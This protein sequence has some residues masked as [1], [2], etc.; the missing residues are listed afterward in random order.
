LL[1]W[2]SLAYFCY[3]VSRQL[4]WALAYQASDNEK[5]LCQQEPVL[6]PDSTFQ[7]GDGKEMEQKWQWQQ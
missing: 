5:L 2:A 1:A 6:L 3:L 7:P 4:V